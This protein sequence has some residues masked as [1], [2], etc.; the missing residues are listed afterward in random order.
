[1]TG[2]IRETA[3]DHVAGENYATFFSSE[4]KWINLIWRLKE[5][6][7]N[8]VDIRNVNPDGSLSAHIP[9][10]W[11]K[12]KP[13]KKVSLTEAQIAASKARL[14]K[15]RLKRLEMLGDDDDARMTKG[16]ESVNYE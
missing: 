14:E 1:M 5:Q 4:A 16:K 7:P 13:K 6:Y 15:G 9:A 2:D 8:E 10:G 3:I 12:I 11:F